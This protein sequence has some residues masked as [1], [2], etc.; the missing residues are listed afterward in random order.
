[1]P[2]VIH[3]D[4]SFNPFEK[5]SRPQSEMQ[6]SNKIQPGDKGWKKL[7]ESLNEVSFPSEP[8]PS[9]EQNQM[10]QIGKNAE[11]PALSILQI[12]NRYLVTAVL[13]GIMIIDQVRA[14]ERV[15]YEKFISGWE[16]QKPVAQQQLLPETLLLSHE[17]AMLINEFHDEFEKAGFSI[18]E[19]GKDTFLIQAVPCDGPN[20]DIKGWVE[21]M[22]ESLKTH[23][24][25]DNMNKDQR[26]AK[27]MAKNIASR[28]SRKM[29]PEESSSLIEQLLACKVPDMTP[30]GKPTLMMISFEELVK[31]FK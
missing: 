20:T 25:E 12:R 14:T 22:I 21:S 17:D 9:G 26:M 4:P 16:N 7:F 24:G 5:K 13:R 2:P 6:F 1:K 31:K 29:Q 23:P 18:S 10:E 30:D 19:F 15:L 8:T 28:M 3:I 27:S 11:E